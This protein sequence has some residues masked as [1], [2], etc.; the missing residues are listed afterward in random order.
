MTAR[1]RRDG[2]VNAEATY[3]MTARVRRDG[4]V[5]AE[6]TETGTREAL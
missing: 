3:D 6:A 1:V 2:N 5:N 4:N